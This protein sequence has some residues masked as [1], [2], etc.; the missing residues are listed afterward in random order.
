MLN[1]FKRFTSP[2]ISSLWRVQVSPFLRAFA[3]AA[4]PKKPAEPAKPKESSL[5]PPTS[6]HHVPPD[7]ELLPIGGE[8]HYR[9]P[10]PDL[11]YLLAPGIEPKAEQRAAYMVVDHGGEIYHVFDASKIP[12]GRMSSKIAFL[13]Q[14]KHKPCF[15]RDAAIYGDKCVVVNAGN[16]YITGQKKHKKVVQ[17][18]TGYIGKLK[19]IPYRRFIEEKPEQL[20]NHSQIAHISSACCRFTFASAKCFQKICP[21]QN[22]LTN[23]TFSVGQITT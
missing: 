6:F 15:R 1:L 10:T 5:P 19:T 17:Y 18:H 14:G 22:Y 20:V 13:L 23:S 11:Q 2:A 16:L 9:V 3:A 7:R 4:P 8:A 21:D 12:F